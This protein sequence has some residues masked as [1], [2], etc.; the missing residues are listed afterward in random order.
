MEDFIMNE[1]NFTKIKDA[2]VTIYSKLNEKWNSIPKEADHSAIRAS[3]IRSFDALSTKL[4]DKYPNLII[5]AGFSPNDTNKLYIVAIDAEQLHDENIKD[6]P[7]ANVKFFMSNIDSESTLEEVTNIENSYSEFETIIKELPPMYAM[8]LAV[9]CNSSHTI[10]TFISKIIVNYYGIESIF[11]IIKEDLKYDKCVGCDIS[12]NTQDVSSVANDILDKVVT[13][14]SAFEELV[15]TDCIDDG[16]TGCK[17]I[18]DAGLDPN[19][20]SRRYDTVRSFKCNSLTT[21][22]Y[23][24]VVHYDSAADPIAVDVEAYAFT[25]K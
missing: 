2:I 6:I 4:G 13:I 19:L 17:A 7:A 22:Y 1:L 21:N 9:K 14:A 10:P 20:I 12:S 8:I 16:T 18:A 25:S 3:V 15:I 5:H 11:T 24:M 23:N